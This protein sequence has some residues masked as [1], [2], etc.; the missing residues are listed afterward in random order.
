MIR[1][2]LYPLKGKVHDR[3]T[4]AKEY[5][6]VHLEHPEFH[7]TTGPIERSQAERVMDVLQEEFDRLG[8]DVRE[9]QNPKAREGLS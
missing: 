1:F 2:T 4:E 9:W 7:F 3:S 5:A 8:V 6:E